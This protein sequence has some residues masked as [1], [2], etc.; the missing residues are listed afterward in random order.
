MGKSR[1]SL[2]VCASAILLI[3]VFAVATVKTSAQT[4]ALCNTGV[5]VL[6]WQQDTGTD[7]TSGFSYRTGQ[8]MSEPTITYSTITDR[9]FRAALLGWEKRGDRRN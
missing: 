4:Q 3:L 6:T 8:N 5:C 2:P 1:V 7:M 9:Q